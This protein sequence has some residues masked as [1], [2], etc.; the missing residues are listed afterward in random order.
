[1]KEKKTFKCLKCEKSIELFLDNEKES[2]YCPYCGIY[3]KIPRILK[4]T[5]LCIYL[6]EDEMMSIKT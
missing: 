6:D 2:V 5:N 4:I 1:M 3:Q